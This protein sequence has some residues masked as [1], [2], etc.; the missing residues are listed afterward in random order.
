MQ[1]FIAAFIVGILVG[2][3]GTLLRLPAWLV[4]LLSPVIWFTVIY[5]LK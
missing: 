1:T 2:F 4:L 3:A 5:L